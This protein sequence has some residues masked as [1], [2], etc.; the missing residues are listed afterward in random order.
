MDDSTASGDTRLTAASS[1]LDLLDAGGDAAEAEPTRRQKAYEAVARLV[2]SRDVDLARRAIVELT[3]MGL[4]TLDEKNPELANQVRNQGIQ[5]LKDTATMIRDYTLTPSDEAK[6]AEFYK[7]L[8]PLIKDGS[9]LQKSQTELILRGMLEPANDSFAD[10]SASLRKASIKALADLGSRGSMEAI[11]E[12][13]TGSS[14][15]GFEKDW[16]AGV[17]YEALKALEQM[18]DPMLRPTV[19]SILNTETDPSVSLLLREVR[20]SQERLDPTSEQYKKR[21]QETA[22]DLMH[23]PFEGWTSLKAEV[24]AFKQ[25]LPADKKDQALSEFIR[26]WRKNNYWI[27]D[28]VEFNQHRDKK[29]QE[30]ADAVYAGFVGSIDWFFSRRSTINREENKAR[31]AE[32]Q[33]ITDRRNSD[34]NALIEKASLRNVEGMKAKMALVDILVNGGQPFA[35]DESAWAQQKAAEALKTMARPGQENRDYAVWAI[36]TGLTSGPSMDPVARRTL[37]D[38]LEN[39]A[40]EEGRGGRAVCQSQAAMIA[41]RAL[42]LQNNLRAPY[43]GDPTIQSRLIGLLGT[44]KHHRTY[45][46]LQAVIDKRPGTALAAQ[47]ERVLADLRDSV[48]NAWQHM[49]EDVTSPQ[50]DRAKS[51]ETVLGENKDTQITVETIIASVKGMPI[52]QADDPRLPLLQI[53]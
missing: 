52:S 24:E 50:A 8:K 1:L 30:A 26:N 16:D 48:I 20:F 12:R 19:L 46:V 14:Q 35:S 53:A 41:A 36:E 2:D 47:A 34:F 38:G 43:Q 51:L 17:R 40:K 49:P 45:P 9:Q 3:P 32:Y 23:D 28:G 42:D 4:A 22:A 44:Y 25:N 21:Y 37:L 29:A 6:R 39:L 5:I 10:I 27:L 31:N 7:M 11:A 13:L 15:K 33:R 18:K